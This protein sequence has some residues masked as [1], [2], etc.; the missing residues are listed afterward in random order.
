MADEPHKLQARV[1]T[2]EGKVYE[3]EA[4]QVSTRTVV[5]EI[6]VRARHAPMLARLVPHE[7]RI[8]E[9]A[10]DFD[11]SEGGRRFA[12]AEGWLEVFANKVTVLVGEAISPDDLDTADL[13]SRIEDAEQ[14]LEEAEEDSA[15]HSAAE[16]EKVRA[17]AFLEIAGG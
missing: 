13:K 1:L 10:S 16:Q 4:F 12:S 11:S 9:D 14:R 2:P 7:L 17:E 15:Q 6:G 5:G 8:Y 3:G